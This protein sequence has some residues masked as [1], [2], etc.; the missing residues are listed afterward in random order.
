MRREV[1]VTPRLAYTVSEV[2]LSVKKGKVTAIEFAFSAIAE[3]MIRR[4][5]A[6]TTASDLS[7]RLAVQYTWIPSCR[8]PWCQGLGTVTV[9]CGHHT[10]LVGIEQAVTSVSPRAA[11]ASTRGARRLRTVM[12]AS[13]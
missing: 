4:D 1:G 11:P 9:E 8:M 13:R 7:S 10:G 12:T 3:S 6:R 2:R 5:F